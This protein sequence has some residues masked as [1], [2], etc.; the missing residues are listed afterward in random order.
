MNETNNQLPGLNYHHIGLLVENIEESIAHYT[1]IFGKENISDV[2]NVTSQKVKVCFVKISDNNYIELVEPINEDSVVYKLLKKRTSYYHIAYKVK[3]IYD[4]VNRL[5]KL[6]YKT[7][8]FF[9]SEACNGKPCVFLYTPEAH[10][11][12]LIEE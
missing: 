9:N 3:D 1:A 7:L 10:L 4:M 8:E 6:N 5:E 12:E 2:F 11:I